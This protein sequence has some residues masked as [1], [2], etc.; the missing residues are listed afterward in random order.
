M[1]SP[2]PQS[3]SSESS[4]Q[5]VEIAKIRMDGGTQPRAKLFEEVV[6]DYAEDMKRGAKFPPVIIYYDGKEYWLADGFHRVRAKEAIGREEVTAEVHPGTQ[7]DAVL[8]S[9]GANAAHGLRRT[10]ADKRRAVNRLVRDHEW[11]KWSDREIAR[12]CGVSHGFVG[13]IR[14]ELSGRYSQ[15]DESTKN[16]DP[17]T[18]M[19]IRGGT[20]YEIDT[21]GLRQGSQA[22]KKKPI[23]KRTKKKA[24]TTKPSE[25][26]TRNVNQGDLWKLGK[27]H[28]LFCGDPSSKKFQG[29]LPREIGLF[30]IFLETL[31][32]WPKTIP[33]NSMNALLFYTSHG[34]DFHL[35][36][37]RVITENCVSGTT[38]AN[39]PVVMINLIDPSLFVLIDVLECP[40]YCAE[41]DPQRCS[42]A[43]TAWSV[44]KQ[45]IRK[46]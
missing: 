42:D 35:E 12:R 2:P 7:R 19:A 27:S 14:A 45:P 9:V 10:N 39:D 25:E 44:T 1:P 4:I 33:E 23:R 28:Y 15:M 43:L 3:E 6:A 21:T 24:A 20:V 8:H 32:D 37:I 38:D 29:L 26:Q 22:D 17:N 41:P 40:C 13:V 11:R 5:A 34:E 46:V 16:V 31:E 30:M 18:R 36:T